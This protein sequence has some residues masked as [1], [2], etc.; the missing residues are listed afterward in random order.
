VKRFATRNYLILAIALIGVSLVGVGVFAST[1][2]TLNSSQAVSLGAGAAAVNVCG[3][4]A[5]IST[6]QYFDSTHQA[7][8]TGTISVSN[9][10][11]T[12]QCVGKT[13]S[14]AFKEGS[15]VISATWPI[16]TGYTNYYFG[17][18]SSSSNSTPNAYSATTLTGFDTAASALSTIALAVQ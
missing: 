1:S 11:A 7:F 13:L 6:Q 16:Q 10:N 15:N 3:S 14:L 8:Y 17:Q 5:T 9:I 2:I 18:L 12:D 4:T